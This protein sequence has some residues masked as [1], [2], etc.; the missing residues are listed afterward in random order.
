MVKVTYRGETRNIPYKYL[1]GL[2]GEEKRKQIKSIFQ[3]KDRPKTKFKTK[4]SQWVEKYEKKYGHKITDTNYMYKNI[5]TKTGAD[6]IIDKGRGAYYSSGSR[7]NQTNESWAQARLASVI[8]NGPARKVDKNIWEKY[9]KIDKRTNRKSINRKSIN[10]KSIN[11]KSINR[12]RTN[13]KRTNRKR[14]NRKK[15]NRRKRTNRKSVNRGV[16][17]FFKGG[18]IDELNNYP[19]N[20]EYKFPDPVFPD[21]S[22]TN[23]TN[24]KEYSEFTPSFEQIKEQRNREKEANNLAMNRIILGRIYNEIMKKTTYERREIKNIFKKNDI[25]K[26]IRL[27]PEIFKKLVY[28][29]V[30]GKILKI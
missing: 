16:L 21:H 23:N 18:G 5:I 20:I 19:F 10:R 12:K 25:E 13:R 27:S 26:F 6:K 8:V 11:R 4:R 2:K 14:T 24:Q 30:D 22:F 17:S 1:R 3:N 7:P 9:N 15:T 28:E 29:I